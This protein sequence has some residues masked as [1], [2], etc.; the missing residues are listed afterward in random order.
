MKSGSVDF[1]TSAVIPRVVCHDF[2]ILQEENAQSVSVLGGSDCALRMTIQIAAGVKS[3]FNPKA[4][5]VSTMTRT[6]SFQMSRFP[7]HVTSLSTC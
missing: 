6:T 2:F 5:A 7:A 1:S 3:N 4:I